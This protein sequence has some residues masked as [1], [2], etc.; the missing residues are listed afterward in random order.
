V[1]A[2]VLR[3]VVG[4]LFVF[5]LA[6]STVYALVRSTAGETGTT[7]KSIN[8]IRCNRLEQLA[9]HIHAHLDIF[10]G[11]RQITVPARIGI[12]SSGLCIYWIHTHDT[13]GVIHIEAPADQASRSFTLGDFL[14]IWG[15]GPITSTSVAGVPIGHGQQLVVIVDGRHYT[16]DPNRILLKAHGRITLE[17]VPPENPQPDFKIR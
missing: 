3:L 14:A 7:P 5:V 15:K 16:G 6:G 17:I 8:G 10:L 4:G 13:T 2:P 9:L 1:S 11:D 12:P